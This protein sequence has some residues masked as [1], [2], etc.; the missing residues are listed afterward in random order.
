MIQ[1][2][3]DG[4]S[5]DKLSHRYKVH[6]TTVMQSRRWGAPHRRTQQRL[7]VDDAERAV[8]SPSERRYVTSIR[9][10]DSSPSS[11]TASTTI[12]SMGPTASSHFWRRTPARF[13]RDSSSTSTYNHRAIETCSRCDRH[14]TI[15]LNNQRAGSGE[16]F[17]AAHAHAKPRIDDHLVRRISVHPCRRQGRALSSSPSAARNARTIELGVSCRKLISRQ[18]TILTFP[19]PHSAEPPTSCSPLIGGVCQRS[20]NRLAMRFSLALKS[21]KHFRGQRN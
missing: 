15:Q 10:R 8:C 13:A 14:A 18:R 7:H 12:A 2:Y 19:R 6:R 5:I 3:R 16:P 11:Q 4:D 20:R 9:S 17:A 1:Q 21:S